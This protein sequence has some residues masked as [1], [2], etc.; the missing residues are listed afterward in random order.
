MAVERQLRLCPFFEDHVHRAPRPRTNPTMASP[1]SPPLPASPAILLVANTHH[2]SCLMDVESHILNRLLFHG[3]RPFL[4]LSFANSK[5]ICLPQERMR[6]CLRG[7]KHIGQDVNS[8][9]GAQLGRAENAHD[10]CLS[11][12]AVERAVAA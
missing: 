1:P 11:M 2:H 6:K 9:D 7:A 4:R 12:G 8:G 5:R 10:D 3:S